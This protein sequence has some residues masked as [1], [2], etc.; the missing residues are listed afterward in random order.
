MRNS[1]AEGKGGMEGREKPFFP[2]GGQRM[3]QMTPWLGVWLGRD[4][5]R[6]GREGRKESVGFKASTAAE[7][8]LRLPLHNIQGWHQGGFRETLMM[9]L[10]WGEGKELLLLLLL[11]LHPCHTRL[12]TQCFRKALE[13]S[14][15]LLLGY[16]F[17]VWVLLIQTQPFP[18]SCTDRKG[19]NNL[20]PQLFGDR[21]CR[22]LLPNY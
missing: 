11:C 3:G 7:G 6:G 18:L 5:L 9:M 20:W 10:H 19:Q 2:L 22:Y 8:V 15:S 4:P 21:N 1:M 13:L 14:S 16:W 17:G 12:A